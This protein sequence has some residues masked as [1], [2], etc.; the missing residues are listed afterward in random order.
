MR[1][2]MVVVSF[3]G[4]LAACEDELTFST[5]DREVFSGEIIDAPFLLHTIGEEPDLLAPG[6]VM[7][8]QL[9]MRHLDGNP[10]QVTTSDGLLD[11]VSLVTLPEI[12]CDRLSALEIPGNFLR[13]L[14]FLAPTS[15]PALQGTDAI[16]FVSLGQGDQVEVRLLSGAGAGRRLF[17]VFRLKREAVSPDD[18]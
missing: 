10:G 3:L 9:N 17:G 11:Q 2:L 13:S 8:L 1:A 18:E 6:T 16:L 15:P 4:G 5:G 14:V 7:N 12:T